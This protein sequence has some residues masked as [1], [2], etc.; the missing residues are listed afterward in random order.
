MSEKNG[1]A[2][3]KKREM[4]AEVKAMHRIESA[5]RELSP[6]AMARVG[7]WAKAYCTDIAATKA[8][9]EAGLTDDDAPMPKVHGDEDISF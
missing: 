2:A 4:A 1:T 3:T 9:K 8:F 7:D 6:A 5:I